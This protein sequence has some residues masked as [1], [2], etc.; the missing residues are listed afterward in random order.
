[1]DV[2]LN[3]PPLRRES[4][5]FYDSE[6]T[7]KDLRSQHASGKF[8]EADLQAQVIQQVQDTHTDGNGAK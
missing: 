5:D 2:A 1:M 4:Y 8:S 3:E 6:K 7:Y